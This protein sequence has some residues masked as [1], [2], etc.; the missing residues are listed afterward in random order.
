MT[1][2]GRI[3]LSQPMAA[4]TLNLRDRII[5]TA[6]SVP[7]RA[8]S[9]R[10]LRPAADDGEEGRNDSGGRLGAVGEVE[11]VVRDPCRR[12]RPRAVC[13]LVDHVRHAEI[14]Q[15]DGKESRR[16]AADSPRCIQSHTDFVCAECDEL[17]G[18]NL[19]QG[20]IIW[21]VVVLILP[22]VGRTPERAVRSSLAGRGRNLPADLLHPGKVLK[23]GWMQGKAVSNM[24]LLC[25]S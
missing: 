4:L 11:G 22:N 20:G 18:R 25:P 1:D 16:E 24:M 2:P 6:M 5:H 17:A 21:M 19:M 9:A 10:P 7:A 13:L 8:R 14:R 3:T 12:Q 23:L 15:R